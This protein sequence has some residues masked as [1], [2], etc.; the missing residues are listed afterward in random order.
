MGLKK[1][2]KE[3]NKKRVKVKQSESSVSEFIKRPLPTDEEVGKFEDYIYDKMEESNKNGPQLFND[4]E[5][6]DEIKNSLSEI[7]KDSNG[8]QVNVKQMD[9]KKKRG[10]IFW[11]FIVMFVIFIALATGLA[12]YYYVYNVSTNLEDIKI[13]V[14]GEE[15][16]QANKEFS[17]IIECKNES[18]VNLENVKVHLI[19]PKN[20]DFIQSNPSLNANNNVWNISTIFSGSSKKIKIKGKIIGKKNTSGIILATM[21]YTPSNFSSEFSKEDS[22]N[23]SI[24]GAG[25]QVN[26]E[27]PK[28]VLVEEKETINFK[29]NTKEENY[30][31][32]F[33]LTANI[34][35]NFT[36]TDSTLSS[37]KESSGAEIEEIE[38]GVWQ[39]REVNK[40]SYN[41]NIEFKV[42]NK[43][44][45]SEKL[46]FDFSKA[47]ENKNF[48]FLEKNI[49]MEVM[50]SNMDLNLIIEGAQKGQSVNFGQKLNYTLTYANKGDSTMNNVVLMAVLDSEYL[51][52]TTLNMTKEGVEKGHTIT[53]TKDNLPELENI[54]PDEEGVIDFSINVLP[55]REGMLNNS[56]EFQIKSYAQFNIGNSATT[57]DNNLDNKSNTIISPI[58]SD[59][60]LNAKVRYFNK[61]NLPVGTGSLPPRVGERT[62]FKVYWTV[63]NNLHKLEESMVSVKLPESINW[64]GKQ[65]TSVGDITYNQDT[66]EVV[67]EIGKM[68]ITVY[69]VDAQF[70]IS[71]TPK[72]EDKNKILVLLP[73]STVEAKDGK[74]KTILKKKTEPTTT[75]LKDDEIANMNSDGIIE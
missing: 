7:Y 68:P 51:D 74:T 60:D 62:T 55:F 27:Y 10:I 65:R 36:I 16:I 49:T 28:S 63:T 54:H 58:N 43:A 53:W 29:I 11:F 59:L 26:S 35:E 15:N 17:Y 19:Y 75:K 23:T 70:D 44:S 18:R 4:K 1:N 64:N 6:E 73:E 14:K 5:R 32:N 72:Q 48:T 13:T 66:H 41:L 42:D 61:N 21:H 2:K 12:G 3:E 22:F 57:T 8:N 47:A 9:I 39:V 56:G 67:W 20:F 31:D 33:K 52:W 25:I 45:S 40:G 69:R 30:I 37:E 46:I 24:K 38:T 34:P 50:E 71:L